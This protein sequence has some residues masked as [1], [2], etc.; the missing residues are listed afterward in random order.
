M[1]CTQS[2]L[3]QL[4]ILC[5]PQTPAMQLPQ[6]LTFSATRFPTPTCPPL[7]YSPI[8]LLEYLPWSTITWPLPDC[9]SCHCSCS[10][11]TITAII[12]SCLFF[13]H[14]FLD[15]SLLPCLLGVAACLLLTS[16]CL[17][18]LPLTLS[19]LHLLCLLI[20]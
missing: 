4:F 5:L 7:P 19:P 3:I 2:F 1:V 11:P 12:A 16:T 18:T 20:I 8:S 10:F 9:L 15:R 14:L 6:P 17:L 13:P